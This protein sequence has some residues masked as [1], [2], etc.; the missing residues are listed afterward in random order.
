LL[1]EGLRNQ[2]R[3][4]DERSTNAWDLLQTGTWLIVLLGL[5]VT[6]AAAYSKDNPEARFLSVLGAATITAGTAIIAFYDPRDVYVSELRTR[7]AIAALQS[8]VEF[9]LV[10]GGVP[11]GHEPSQ[12]APLSQYILSQWQDRLSQILAQDVAKY[13]E[14]RGPKGP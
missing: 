12:F 4:L 6:V 2:K 7:T 5:G 14:V 11:T 13:L 10:Q 1:R 9:A 8:E 3:T